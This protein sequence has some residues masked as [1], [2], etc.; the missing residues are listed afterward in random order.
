MKTFFKRLLLLSGLLLLLFV[1]IVLVLLNFFED[2]IG[3]QVVAELNTQLKTEIR[4]KG[5][6]L[7]F[8]RSFPNV[9]ANLKGVELDGTD[10][11]LLLAANELSFRAGLFSLFGSQMK[12]KSVVI[13]DGGL[14]LAT[15]RRGRVNYEIFR[16]EETPTED[17]GGAIDLQNALVNNMQLRY[18][19]EQ[20]GQKLSI[21]VEKANFAGQFGSARYQ[22]TST[23][24]LQLQLLEMDGKQQLAGQAISYDGSFDVD[25]DQG[26]YQI[27]R[28]A[29]EVG[30]LPLTTSGMFQLKPDETLIDLVFA[31]D[32]GNLSDLVS[33]LPADYKAT[34][35]GIDSRGDF[36]FAATVKGTHSERQHPRIDAQV[37]FSDG[38]ISGERINARVR[39]LGFSANYTNGDLHDEQ[40]SRLEI[41]NLRGEFEREPFALNLIIDNFADPYIDFTA[42]GTLVPGV[43]AGFLP[44]ERITSGTGKVQ[45]RNLRLKGRYEDMIRT[46]RVGQVDM[47]G[48]LA[49]EEAGFTVNN[50][51]VL[52]NSGQ[53]NLAGNELSAQEINFTAQDTRMTFNG[54]V[55]NLL[56]VIFADSLNSKD[57]ILTF[58]AELRADALDIGQLLA[59]GAP[60]AAVQEAAAEAG[61]TDSLAQAQVEK[62]AFKTHF[63][64]GVFQAKIQQFKYGNIQ[65]ENFQG[66]V[67]FKDGK[68]NIKGDTKA[69]GGDFLL[70][71]EMVFND[72]PTLN[73]KLT[74]NQID[75]HEFFRQADNFGQDV[76]VADNLEG[77]LDAR[78]YIQAYFDEE[79]NFL[80]DKLRVL[81]G[82]G[83]KD[84]RLKDF[85]M[86]QDFSTFV[87]IRD[88]REIRFTNLENYFEISN[89]KLYL[90]VMFIQSNALNLTV[91]GE[92]TFDQDISYYVKVNAGQVMADRFR[93][94]NTKLR[95][96]PAKRRGFFNLYYA[97]LGNIDNFDFASDKRRV[98]NDFLASER[99]KR[100]IHY[101]L[102][103]LFGTV[104]ELVEEPQDWRD[105]PEHQEDPNSKEPE[106]L[107]MEIDG[108]R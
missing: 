78:L 38:S 71:G 74:C 12:L 54:Q 53:I 70:D 56:P 27:D 104:I 6:E 92:H 1:G 43:V 103:R 16:T 101:E 20:T 95:P 77:R 33:L 35:A 80:E 57:A 82:V 88:L 34:L 40:T 39:D 73:A 15:D 9:G 69:M 11:E 47:Q 58:R 37:D 67:A 106:F 26:L 23:A 93:R 30:E 13:S 22:L 108:G 64:D 83:I 25:S 14:Y 90:P 3:Q 51:E 63:L 81:G 49:F 85:A 59:L 36:N 76:L 4:I 42:N 89:R 61:Q 7:S 32:G 21:L 52:F 107:D 10:G 96:K 17:S 28:F 60:A 31:S 68:M 66:E 44:D 105:I 24:D 84:G 5:F 98:Q 55:T 100:D 41:T 8:L 18:R 94:H 2:R 46:S 62:R 97:I 45:I 102:E 86:L 29:L 72:Q 75:A 79:G 91:S 65:G 87:D 48:V 99:R 50:E 19:D